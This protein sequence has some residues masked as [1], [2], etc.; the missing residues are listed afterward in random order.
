MNNQPR[1]ILLLSG[2]AVLLGLLGGGAAWLLVRAIAV[3]TN[4]ALFH[5]WGTRLPN[6]K[7]LPR[8]PGVVLVAMVGA[9]V[10]TLMA[11]WAPLIR[12]DGI[13]QTMDAVLTRRS[14]IS[15][16]T[17]LAKPLSAAIAIGTSAPFGAEGPIIVTGG[18][19]GSLVGQIV[20]VSASERK[21]L[22]ACGAAAGMSATFGTPLGAVLL[23]IELL[24]FEFSPRAFIPLAVSSAMAGGVHALAFGNG[25]LFDAPTHVFSGLTQ[26]PLFAGL[27][28]ACGLLAFVITRGLFFCEAMFDRIP[29]NHAWNPIIGAAVF[30][31]LGLLVPRALGVGYDVI[32]DALASRLT[33]GTLA[34]LVAG[35]I[36]LWCIALASGTSGGTL[37]PILLMGATFGALLGQSMAKEF[38]GIGLAPSAFALVAMAATFGATARAPFAA[39][40]LLFEL[41]RDY[42]AI[43]PLMLATV[44]A[45]LL[46]RALLPQSIMTAKLAHRGV[47]VPS[48]FHADPWRGVLVGSAMSTDMVT[49]PD[50]ADLD[51]TRAVFAS[52]THNAFPI[53]DRDGYVTGVVSR[54]DLL[55]DDHVGST[56]I[57]EVATADAVTV[58]VGDPLE[59][60]L[61]V[62]IEES[63]NLLPVTDDGRLV[64]VCTRTDILS[65]RA[66]E[67]DSDRRERG[68]LATRQPRLQ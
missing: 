54:L 56:P 40:V 51:A 36:V 16:R 42:N 62:M 14:R 49:I 6:F 48:E 33:I 35:K 32:G 66:S 23:A 41:T 46:A 37:A 60:A 2:L 45:D 15:P 24:L 64:G 55:D 12:G 28:L 13:P 10:I 5:R 50:D 44:L 29:F 34:T 47:S 53:V 17:A 61:S 11:R 3:I 4:F 59:R 52:S 22:L 21:I 58:S 30:A 63:L 1:R 68:W 9:A 57:V 8:G 43:L 7:D 26:L 31:S 18:A 39:I 19:L 25:P 20:H 65:L 67:S 38:P 27:G